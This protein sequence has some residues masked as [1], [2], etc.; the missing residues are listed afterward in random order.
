MR[1]CGRV[2]ES[3]GICKE[4]HKRWDDCKREREREMERE[5]K[6]G[7]LDLAQLEENKFEKDKESR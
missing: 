4:Q 1:A 7:S 6:E 3:Q 2:W 5:A